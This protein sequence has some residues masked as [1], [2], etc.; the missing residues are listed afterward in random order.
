MLKTLLVVQWK[1][2]SFEAITLLTVLLFMR[3][4]VAAGIP[5]EEIKELMTSPPQSGHMT[6]RAATAGQLTQGTPTE[7]ST[8][9]F[10]WAGTD[11][12]IVPN[13]EVSKNAPIWAASGHYR[14]RSWDY[15]GSNLTFFGSDI[16]QTDSLGRRFLFKTLLNFG[17]QN[18][19][20]GSIRWQ[21][22][23]FIGRLEHGLP[24]RGQLKIH[25]ESGAVAGLT[26]RVEKAN[27]TYE[28]NF[29]NASEEGNELNYP[30]AI[31]VFGLDGGRKKPLFR[32]EVLVAR[33][34]KTLQPGD[35]DP[36]SLFSGARQVTLTKAGVR[37]VKAEALPDE[38]RVAPRSVRLVLMGLFLLTSFGLAF[39]VVKNVFRR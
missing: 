13:P 35:L 26:Y 30:G 32:F 33:H 25:P 15:F 16:P 37:G 22:N 3:H 36:E 12:V 34:G 23:E 38:R 24:I 1:N 8:F 17:I 20:P 4:G 11:V 21:G 9:E 14:S 7:G 6:V 28:I 31:S 19:V 10:R 5:M 39:L 18:L 2:S 27:F 29:E